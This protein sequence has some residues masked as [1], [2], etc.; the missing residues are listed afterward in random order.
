MKLRKIFLLISI[1]AIM[2]GVNSAHADLTCTLNRSTTGASV[3]GTLTVNTIGTVAATNITAWNITVT[4][5]NPVN[6][7]QSNSTL[8]LGS[9]AP[10]M[11]S[12]ANSLTIT[13]VAAASLPSGGTSRF[14]IHIG[15]FSGQF[16]TLGNQNHPMMGTS[17]LEIFRYSGTGADQVINN[18]PP[19]SLNLTCTCVTDANVTCPSTPTPISA[20]SGLIFDKEPQ[21]YSEEIGFQ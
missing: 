21:I 11:V 13:P 15:G 7:T 5:T 9:A 20:P 16:Y 14:Y 8:D 1:L 3:S 12:T 6:F 19:A 18:S 17:S 4:T 2:G 10:T